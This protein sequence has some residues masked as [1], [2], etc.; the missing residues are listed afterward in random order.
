M[1]SF[2]LFLPPTRQIVQD[3]LAIKAIFV[4]VGG[5]Y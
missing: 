4:N 3:P 5:E 1:Q 2:D